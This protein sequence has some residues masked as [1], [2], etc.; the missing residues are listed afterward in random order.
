MN[1]LEKLSDS[2]LKQYYDMYKKGM[3]RSKRFEGRKIHNVDLKF[4]YHIARLADECEQI[5][6]GGDLDLQ[7]SREYMKAIRRG[8][9]SE[10]D[11]RAWFS[12]KEKQL[13]AL[14]HSSSLPYAPDEAAIKKLLF[15]CLEEHYGNL[16]RVVAMPDKLKEGLLQIESII[17][18]LHTSL[19]G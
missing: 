1:Q 9:V 17:N 16:D 11:L 8:E 3:S 12:N 15:H 10:E 18:K 2:Q 14:Y 5:L 7:R 6:E 13:E 4:L 19:H